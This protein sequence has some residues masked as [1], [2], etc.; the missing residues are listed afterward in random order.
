MISPGNLSCWVG[1]V[2]LN[3]QEEGNVWLRCVV[4]TAILVR[5][6]AVAMS[7]QNFD[8][9]LRPICSMGNTFSSDKLDQES[10]AG[11]ATSRRKRDASTEDSQKSWEVD[12]RGG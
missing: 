6:F 12:K 7:S 2:D 9:W 11:T 1:S 4:S 8:T 10:S 5:F 3:F